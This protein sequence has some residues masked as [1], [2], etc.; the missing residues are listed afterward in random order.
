MIL[1]GGKIY[2][3]EGLRGEDYPLVLKGYQD[4][5][6]IGFVNFAK[7]VSQFKDVEE[8]KEFVNGIENETVFGIYASEDKFIGYATLEPEG[9]DACEYAIFILD[10]KY[11]GEGIGEEVTKIMLD[12]VFNNLG[13]KKATLTVAELHEK[14]ITLYEEMGFKKVKIIPNDRE[15][16]LNGKWIK[17]GTL[18]ME[19]IN[20]NS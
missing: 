10:K 13:F 12:Y 11:W 8:A 9:E 20:K 17:S 4:L 5:G 7:I 3:K 19:F 2:L 15:I 18:E 6:V 14:A 1:N 16:F